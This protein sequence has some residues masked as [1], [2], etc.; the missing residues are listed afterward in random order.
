MLLICQWQHFKALQSKLVGDDRA[1]KNAHKFYVLEFQVCAP[2][3][4][5]LG[6]A[7]HK[8]PPF[9]LPSLCPSS[10]PLLE[11]PHTLGRS[12]G[13]CIMASPL[14][15][16]KGVDDAHSGAGKKQQG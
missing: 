14:H 8:E 2:E 13:G 5:W 4:Q 1:F 7:N 3:Q 12:P 9:P 16:G 11:F 10:N 15:G 6:I